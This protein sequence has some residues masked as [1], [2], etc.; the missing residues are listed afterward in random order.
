LQS[1]YFWHVGIKK[2]LKSKFPFILTEAEMDENYSLIDGG[3]IRLVRHALY[4]EIHKERE[5]EDLCTDVA[6][7]LRGQT[8]MLCFRLNLVRLSSAV[9]EAIFKDHTAVRLVE[10]DILDIPAVIK[11]SHLVRHTPSLWLSQSV[12]TWAPR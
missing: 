8:I 10:T 2:L 11:H 7:M 12:R 1:H 5:R 9:L 6:R 3:C 4:S